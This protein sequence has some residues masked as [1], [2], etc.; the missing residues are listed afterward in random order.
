[1]GEVA[2]IRDPV[3]GMNVDIESVKHRHVYDEREL[4]FC[5]PSCKDKFVATP[6]DYLTAKDPVCGMNVDRAT[7]KYM[8][9]HQSL[10]YYF[11]CEG[12]QF[13]F[14][15]DPASYLGDVVAPPPAPA[16]TKYTCPMDPEIVT[17][18][19]GDCPICGMALEPMGVPPAD[20]GPNPELVDFTRRFWVS[21]FFAVPLL[22]LTMGPMVGLPIREWIGENIARWLELLLAAPVVLWAAQPVFR[23]GW[24]S[25]VNRSPN[26]WTLIA[27]G[28]GVAFVFSVVA[29]LV[30]GI[31]PSQFSGD[32]GRTPLYFEA[33]AVI[34][35]LVFVGQILEL[36][37]REQTG[38]ALRALLDLAPKT[39]LQV[40]EN[41]DIEMSLDEV[42]VDDY[43]RVRPGD[44]V[45]V[46]G[47]VVSGQSFVD[48]SL[49]LQN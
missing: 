39:A 38:S 12:C 6:T 5:N 10:R 7:A 23:R 42:K 8:S 22:I 37:A 47:V 30:P 35:A 19:F 2:I 15:A 25:V 44:A 46:D 31:L 16:G 18:A 4:G 27:L 40:W 41:Q 26:M 28:T 29:L 33:S 48:E 43:L 17:D 3:C 32:G 14:E 21:V 34:I 49:K 11:C 13:K 36:R 45:P 20:A 24:N 1:M 9:K